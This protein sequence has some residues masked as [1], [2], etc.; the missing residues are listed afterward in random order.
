M[1][2]KVWIVGAIGALVYG[3]AIGIVTLRARVRPRRYRPK[4]CLPSKRS[5]SSLFKRPRPLSSLRA[6][7]TRT[8][9]GTLNNRGRATPRHVGTPLVGIYGVCDSEELER[10]PDAKRFR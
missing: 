9:R 5:G 3:A 1:T 4:R 7:A 6:G 2:W 10:S 8:Q